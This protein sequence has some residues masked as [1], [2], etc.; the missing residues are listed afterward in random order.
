MAAAAHCQSLNFTCTQLILI[1]SILSRNTNK[2]VHTWHACNQAT[3]SSS[4]SSTTALLFVP[5]KLENIEC[6]QFRAKHCNLIRGRG[7][8]EEEGSC[9]ITFCQKY[10]TSARTLISTWVS[11]A[12]LWLIKFLGPPGTSFKLVSSL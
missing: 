9:K 12:Q 2:H 7:E 3:Q 11:R 8:E 1:D 10:I 6:K 5:V 4:F